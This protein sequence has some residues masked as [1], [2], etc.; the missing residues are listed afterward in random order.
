MGD[1]IGRVPRHE[2]GFESGGAF[3]QPVGQLLTVHP[4]HDHICDEQVDFEGVL[5]G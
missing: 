3:M 4:R 2:Q 1:D 5:L